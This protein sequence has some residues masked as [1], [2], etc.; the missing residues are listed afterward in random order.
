M[1][2]KSNNTLTTLLC[3]KGITTWEDLLRYIKNLPYGRN[4]N[5]TDFSLVVTENK[6]TCSSK[7]A[8]VAAVAL[9]NEIESVELI[10][11]IYKMNEYNTPIGTLLS[12]KNIDYIPE[13]HCYLKIDGKRVDLTTSNSDFDK[14]E[15]DLLE[16]IKITPTQVGDF[17]V[18]LHKEY[19]EKWLSESEL[20]YTFEAL[21]TLRENCIEALSKN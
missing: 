6:G 21:W 8:L 20:K 13:A 9:E 17:K 12:E 4:E 11:G 18:N 19:L 16:E 5:R 7:H 2:F 1:N 14:I 10:I 15:K 3:L